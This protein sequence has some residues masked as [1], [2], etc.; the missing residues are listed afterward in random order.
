MATR[1]PLT[2][3][4]KERIYH[5]RLCGETLASAA[6]A[7]GCAL[8]T[9]RK[10]WRYG[11]DHGLCAFGVTRRGR[12]PTGLLSSFAP[13]VAEAALTCKRTHPRWGAVRVVLE[14]AREPALSDLRLPKASRL[15]AFFKIQC[16]ECV[17]TPHSRPAPVRPWRPQ[18][19]HEQW[20]LDSQEGIRLGDGGIATICNVRDPVGG[21]ML[22]SAAFAVQ[23]SRH[24]RKL[25]WT[26][27]RGVL[28]RAFTEWQ[29]LP[30]S[31][32]TDNEL[33]LAG[34]P[35]DA[36]PSHLTLWLAGLGIQHTFIRPGQ[37]HDQAEIERNHRTLD[38]GVLD[39]P[40]TQ[41]R[42]T[43]QAR[44]D[45]ERH[46]YNAAY[47]TRA[48]DCA[49]RAP[50]QAHPELCQP[51]RPYTPETELR[52]FDLQRVYAYLATFIFERKVNARG[53][54][55]L[56]SHLY[57][58]GCAQC[59][60]LRLHQVRIRLDA[61]RREW[62]CFAADNVELKRFAP[63][64]LDVPTL[65]GLDDTCPIAAPPVQLTLPFLVSRTGTNLLDC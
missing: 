20:Q 44:L 46:L 33:G 56:G 45:G 19:V 63:V 11:R 9:A 28:R 41:T 43:L 8:S 32:Q 25:H 34:T 17:H 52:L 59:R 37:P 4:E 22:A 13:C 29:T 57:S 27:V 16:P 64:A 7:I 14:L 18:A 30:D 55:S 54:V 23:T 39:A 10:W 26:E 62:V 51:R 61:Q 35:I 2:T 65:T 38:G 5:G 12:P 31:L 53:Q 40:S 47:P 6:Q 21:A 50:L 60:T 3:A 15:A 1:P 49:H 48:S 24:Y 58:L 36:L 42:R